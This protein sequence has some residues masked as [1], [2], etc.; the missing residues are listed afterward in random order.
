MSRKAGYNRHLVSTP[1]PISRHLGAILVTLMMAFMGIMGTPGMDYMNTDH[2]NDDEEK[3]QIIE[4]RP[5]W[6]P[7]VVGLYAVNR[8]LRRPLMEKLKILER[9]LRIA[10]DWN[11]YRDGPSRVRRLNIYVDGELKH[12]SADPEYTWLNPQLRN[13][14]IRPVLENAARKPSI[15][16]WPGIMRFLV[17]MAIEDFP[18][19]T[20]V[21][22][23]STWSRF[24]GNKPEF[25]HGFVAT[26]PDWK[27]VAL[28]RDEDGK[29]AVKTP[30]H[31]PNAKKKGDEGRSLP[32]PEGG[33]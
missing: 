32:T 24:P 17:V 30:K 15:P 14:H 16:N 18:G 27:P 13:R 21:R 33:Q 12:R 10:Q 7:V 2:Y 3:A 31:D 8:E 26:A 9:P 28:T 22:V 1:R 5:V 20:E 11:L 25:Q 4:K 19:A 6:G 29:P 23:E